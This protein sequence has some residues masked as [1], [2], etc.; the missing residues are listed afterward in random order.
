MP[1]R[2]P[3]RI[4]QVVTQREPA[5]AQR[6]AHQLHRA[7]VAEGVPS[8]V[9][10]LYRRADAYDDEPYLDL[11]TR[12]PGPIGTLRLLVELVRR[13]RA[14]RPAA[15]IA[16]TFHASVLAA[17]AGT[18][19]R[20]PRRVAVHHVLAPF[21]RGA[22]RGV[23]RL[24]AATP[25]VHHHVYVS[26]TTLDSYGAAARRRSVVIRNGVDDP[27]PAGPWA[28]PRR[29]PG[30]P[31][32]VAV[33]RLAPQKDHATLLAA[34]EQLPDVELLV[35]G[36][37]ELRPALEAD[38]AA[39][40]LAGRVTLLG[41]VPAEHVPAALAAA[42]VVVQP[43]VWEAYSMVVLEAMAAGRP[44]VVSDIP[45]HREALGSHAR[46]HPVGDAAALAA[47]VR[48]LLDDPTEARALGEGARQAARAHSHAEVARRYL[49]L[50]GL[51]VDAGAP[52]GGGR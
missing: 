11:S 37:G 49:A 14:D 25:L 28:P 22:R 23:L 43:S 26:Q 29:C 7:F 10:F 36:E 32:V 47:A 24:L 20:V 16:H 46:Y 35:L 13:W 19:A 50:V 41:N 2:P 27:A 1:D 48:A 39:R 4:V 12:R 9:L 17:L 40:G 3:G 8:E 34:L 52:V 15:V 51:G 5:G 45:A 18:A 31:L 44:M 42:D 6:V 38:V 21:E 33:G 30:A